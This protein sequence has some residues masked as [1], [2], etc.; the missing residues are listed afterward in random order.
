LSDSTAVA[1]ATM[2]VRGITWL[3]VVQ[4]KDEPRP[5]G[6]VRGERIANRVVQTIARTD[7]ARA[8]T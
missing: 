5:V 4:S 3:P 1:S 6:I 7:H 2:L 8:A